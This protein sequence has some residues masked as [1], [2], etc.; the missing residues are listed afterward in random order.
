M[1]SSAA[2]P[3]LDLA[4]PKPWRRFVPAWLR[5]LI[6]VD[7]VEKYDAFL[8]YSWQ[9]E[10]SRKVA[11]VIQATIQRFLC[12][13]YK[14]RAKSVFRDLSCLP[15]G[16]SL[17]GELCDRL[18]RS[19][20]LIVL[21]SPEAVHSHGM[22]IEARHW[23]SRARQ[24]QVLIIIPAGNSNKWEEIRSYLLP[25]TIASNL[26][27]EPLWISLKEDLREKILANPDD[28]RL[29]EEV[30]EALNQILL[31]FYPGRD[32]GQLRGQESLQRRRARRLVSVVSVVLVGL[33]LYALWSRNQARQETKLALARQLAAQADYVR[34]TEADGLERSALL[35]VQSARE[36]P[37]VENDA[38]LR[39]AL[40]LLPK[41]VTTFRENG[42]VNAVAF[43]P[44]GRLVATGS[45]DKTTRVFDTASSKELWSRTED[46][47]VWAV[48][49]SP[50]G[51]LVATGGVVNIG[52]TGTTHVFDAASGKELWS[53]EKPGA[54]YAVAFS[55][56]GR[57]V[58]TSSLISD[59]RNAGEV[60]GTARVFD[61]ASGKELWSKSEDVSA[62]VAMAFSPDGR[63]VATGSA[64]ATVRV[65]DA[66]SGKELWSKTEGDRVIAVAFSPDGRLVATGSEDKTARVFDAASGK[67]LARQ[68]ED[69]TVNA[70]AFSP[71]GRFIL[72]VD[73]TEARP[74]L[75]VTH[76][77]RQLADLI[78]QACSHLSRNLT[79]EEWKQYIGDATP[80]RTCPNLPWEE[81]PGFS[82]RSWAELTRLFGPIIHKQTEHAPPDSALQ[83]PPVASVAKGTPIGSGASKTLAALRALVALLC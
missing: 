46:G 59:Y 3:S 21:A 14:F 17:E 15:A 24:G 50:D 64:Q 23:F 80:Q 42:Q 39:Q 26:T 5:S 40:A 33:T 76:E 13:W 55:P 20:H 75:I 58:A 81:P 45:I 29:S 31:A 54:V 4:P 52:A 83:T 62:I 6:W 71:D 27:A 74:D 57:L 65:L 82:K 56:D 18:D 51:R 78:E 9:S 25:P 43:S 48:A 47:S 28:R 16:S 32:W 34:I 60:G 70:V 37:L 53:K 38:A 10:S 79:S 30:C 22:E 77:A 61:A 49:F 44:D 66:A 35:A 36:A 19:T 68:I 73:A 67:E 72:T 69:D 11:P 12:P 1:S 41:H 7:S 8:S 63:L 2:I